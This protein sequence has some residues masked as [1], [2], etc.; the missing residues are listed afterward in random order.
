[1]YSTLTSA[2][3]TDL[4]YTDHE[5]NRGIDVINGDFMQI[6]G[7]GPIRQ[8]IDHAR[9][10]GNVS[11]L[12]AGCGTGLGL[13]D[14][15]DQVAFRAPINPEAIEAVGVSMADYSHR[16]DE[17]AGWVN[18]KRLAN[19]YVNIRLGNL[20][21]IDLAPTSFDVG[22]S[23]QVIL[24]NEK[25]EPILENI[26]PALSAGGVF[27]FDTLTDQREEVDS[28]SKDLIVDGWGSQTAT[29]TKT[30]YTGESKARIMN[31]LTAPQ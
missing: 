22:Y 15:K 1:M 7:V 31:K 6:D 20:A 4:H 12:D 19:G 11:L 27:Y 25:V 30:S 10:H 28:I 17:D 13:I 26:L 5:I 29:V 14:L 8:A 24:H 3:E 16:L 2:S 23:Y 9:T 21:T 18:R